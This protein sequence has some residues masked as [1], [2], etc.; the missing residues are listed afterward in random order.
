[1]F[2]YR[3]L[4]IGGGMAAD[5]AI[6][7]IRLVDP[8]A[9]IGMVGDELDPP[10]NRPPLSKA[11]WDGMPMEQ[12][13]RPARGKQVE[14]HLGRRIQSLDLQ[15]RAVRDQRGEVYRYEKLLLAVGGSPR[16]L[17]GNDDG[18]I[19]FRTLADYRRVRVATQLQQAVTVIGGGLVGTEIAAA[20]RKAGSAV[21]LITGLAGP[22]G[23]LLPVAQIKQLD[24]A[25][26]SRG[27]RVMDGVRVSQIDKIT[28]GQHRIVLSDRRTLNA[29]MVVAG[30]GLDPNVD[31][32]KAA[33]LATDHGITVNMHLCT[34][35]ADVFAAGDCTSHWCS[36]LG[37]RVNAQHE[38]HANF[39]G[40]AAGRAMAGKPVEY[41][42][43][44]YFYSR[45]G[46]LAYEGIGVTD[47]KLETHTVAPRGPNE[48]IVYYL[49]AGR[50]RGVLFWNVRADLEAAAN[51][52]ASS[53]LHTPVSLNGALRC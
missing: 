12:V 11:L 47:P 4:I 20:L 40:I 45:V 27:V 39:S 44:P 50:V 10:Y 22:G 30:L 21:T 34:S 6:K 8:E 42:A 7:G 18:V 35:H 36:D 5:S 37:I 15:R 19:Y 3:Y 32:A 49:H 48:V 2:S 31:L 41:S 33:G 25:L 1:M 29:T 38:E 53:D 23:H 24:R 51:L 14:S 17:P 43:L 13:W 46:D 52:I 9:R 26:S 16:R 28:D